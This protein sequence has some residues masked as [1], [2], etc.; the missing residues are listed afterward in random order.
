MSTTTTAA[1]A[2]RSSS[3]PTYR[4]RDLCALTGLSR[5]AIHFYI[6]Q[7]LVPEG[8]KTGRNMAYY[9]AEHVERLRLVR[10][11]QEERYLP[12]KQIRALLDGD[13]A[14]VAESQRGLLLEVRARLSASVRGEVGAGV[15]DI[16]HHAASHGVDAADLARMIELGLIAVRTGDDGARLASPDATWLVDLWGQLRTLGYTRDR[17]FSVDDLVPV[18]AAIAGLFDHEASML[19][20]LSDVPPPRLAEM[21]ERALPVMNALVAQLHAAAVR[22]FLTALDPT[23]PRN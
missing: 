16:D 22:T 17:G 5:Q 3:A 12:L 9:G 18:H 20:R 15:I 1:T 14:G 2:A 6:Q 13:Q 21:V 23:H 11:L 19:R 10:R 4:M 7:G 8:T